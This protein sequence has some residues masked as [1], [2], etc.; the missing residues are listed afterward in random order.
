MTVIEKY[1]FA[2]DAVEGDDS[3]YVGYVSDIESHVPVLVD[4]LAEYNS[5]VSLLSG[6]EKKRINL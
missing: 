6:V 4:L 5:V 3:L 1:N 2:V